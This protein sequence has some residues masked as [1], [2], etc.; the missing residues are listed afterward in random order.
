MGKKRYTGKK[1]FHWKKSRG[2]WSYQETKLSPK[3]KEI[4]LKPDPDVPEKFKWRR[5]FEITIPAD[6]ERSAYLKAFIAKNRNMLLRVSMGYLLKNFS[7]KTHCGI[8]PGATYK[9]VIYQ[10]IKRG[11][12]KMDCR[13]FIEEVKGFSPGAEG[14]ALTHEYAP[15]SLW[16][17]RSLVSFND[18]KSPM[19]GEDG[20]EK[21]MQLFR[22]TID[23]RLWQ[24][25]LIDADSMYGRSY[26]DCLLV[27]FK[28]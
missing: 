12:S 3:D 5:E 27:F 4:V 7:E 8:E 14:L 9:G 24:L 15:K 16:G 13:N 18:P 26:N 21:A 17:V 23:P 6:F 22:H 19:I 25:L 10:S 1:L 2:A 20:K 28:K 11:V